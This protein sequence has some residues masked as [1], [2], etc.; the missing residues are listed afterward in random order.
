MDDGIKKLQ[1]LLSS[2]TKPVEED[3]ALAEA[4]GF[5]ESCQPRLVRPRV[6][7][8]VGGGHACGFQLI[9]T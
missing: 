5:L 4:V 1:E 2:A 6:W 7:V 8:C 9:L 3:D